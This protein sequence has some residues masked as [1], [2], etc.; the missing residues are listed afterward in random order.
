MR[1][2]AETLPR[3]AGHTPHQAGHRHAS[4]PPPGNGT[5]RPRRAVALVALAALIVGALFVGNAF[6]SR[7]RQP[8]TPTFPSRPVTAAEAT[9]LAGVR[10]SNYTAGHAAVF[11]TIGSGLTAVRMNGWV[12]WRQPLIYLNSVGQTAGPDDGMIQAIPGVVAVRP[13]LYRPPATGGTAYAPYPA[14]PIP[15]PPTGWQVRPIEPGSAIDTMI[16]LLFSMRAASIDNASQI[17]AIGTLLVGTDEINGVP[18][19]IIDGAAVPPVAASQPT[20]TP[21]GLPFAA[22]GGQV[23]YWVDAHSRVLRVEALVDPT[24]TLRIDFNRSDRTDPSA[25]ELLGGAANKPT[26]LTAKQLTLLAKMRKA[27]DAAGGGVITL[28]VPVDQQTLYSATG[29]VDWHVPAVYATIRNNKS[30]S[31]DATLRADAAGLTVYGTLTGTAGQNAGGALA[32]PSLHPAP[33]GWKR[34]PWTGYA[35]QYGEQDLELIMNEL[36][37]VSSSMPDDPATLK[38]IASRLRS[39]TVDGVPVTVFEVRQPAEA[40]VTPGYGRLRFW[41]D[42]HGVLRRLELRTRTGAY[43]YI[44]I[45]PGNVPTLPDPVPAT[46]SR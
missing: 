31:P 29:W 20:A 34:T 16:T 5:R 39:D 27:D 44:T 24:T 14:P 19:D 11:V 10:L 2:P 30:S 23:R 8:S 40:K 32:K 15:A 25:I 21:T 9:R 41:V 26:P 6:L 33:S 7:A 35:D 3:T 28:A 45:T 43:G 38:P 17:S 37:A 13:G 22:Q 1:P 42:A 36:L 46:T 18:V 4:T 12:D